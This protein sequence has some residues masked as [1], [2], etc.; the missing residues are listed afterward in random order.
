MEHSHRPIPGEWTQSWAVIGS[1]CGLLRRVIVYFGSLEFEW[2]GMLL[3][4]LNTQLPIRVPLSLLLHLQGNLISSLLKCNTI[5]HISFIWQ[6]S[7][8]NCT[9]LYS[10]RCWHHVLTHSLQAGLEVQLVETQW[11]R[12]ALYLMLSSVKIRKD[13]IKLYFTTSSSLKE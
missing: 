2:P 7:H 4:V 8:P 11:S 10:K 6:S 3:N 1:V 9:R 13:Y 12:S 5:S